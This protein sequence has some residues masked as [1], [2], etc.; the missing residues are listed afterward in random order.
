[1]VTPSILTLFV[2]LGVFTVLVR[3]ELLGKALLTAS[4][5]FLT[6]FLLFC[7]F[8]RYPSLI[9]VVHLQHVSYYAIKSCCVS[10]DKLIF[11]E[12]PA[13]DKTDYKGDRY[14]PLYMVDA[15][16]IHTE[17]SSDKDGFRHNHPKES[18]DVVLIGDSYIA[19]GENEADTFGRRLE[20]L[21]GLSVQNFGVGGYGPFQY[22]EVLKRYGVSKKPKYALLCFYEGNDIRDIRGYLEWKRTG[23][24]NGRYFSQSFL[25]RYVTAL[26]DEFIYI[27][28][29]SW[30]T[31][32][33]AANK[34][35]PR[36]IHPDLA[37]VNLGNKTYELLFHYRSDP[38]PTY[39]IIR[40]TEG[41]EL[42]KILAE[43]QNISVQ[44]G[45]EPVIIY[46]P[47]T[48]HI[49]AQ[50]STDQSGENWLKI[51]QREIASKG[52]V[53]DAVGRMSKELHLRL[54]SLT[55]VFEAAARDGKLLYYPFDTHWNSTGRQIAS[56]FIASSI[57]QKAAQNR[58]PVG[59]NGL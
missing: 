32:Q 35:H 24:Y 21:S 13:S 55:P 6:H 25:R 37:V 51:R 41:Q 20:R 2:I 12:R 43:F 9:R 14:S 56:T 30:T 28:Y 7:L 10:D 27:R 46:I 19:F 18:S 53:E 39:D 1:V 23:K 49:Y 22:L 45:I 15:P 38:R 40:S 58:L 36:N 3:Y 16:S 42:R 17:W 8:E 54:A 11:R 59:L 31:I 44:N 29:V 47:S 50:Y 5:L 34:S 33:L 57:L 48:A 52:N 4:S 26:A